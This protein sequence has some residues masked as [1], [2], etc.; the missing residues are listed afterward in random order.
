ML[1]SNVSGDLKIFSGEGILCNVIDDGPEHDGVI[2]LSSIKSKASS[3]A[4]ILVDT[5]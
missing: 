1:H 2:E 5:P 4:L 3:H